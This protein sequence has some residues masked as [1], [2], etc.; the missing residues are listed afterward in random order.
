MDCVGDPIGEP[1]AGYPESEAWPFFAWGTSPEQSIREPSWQQGRLAALEQLAAGV[2]HYFTGFLQSI[3]IFAQQASFH[4]DIPEAARLNVE[5]IIH[6]ALQAADR[7]GQLRDFSGQSGPSKQPID[8]VSLVREAGYLLKRTLPSD[9]QLTVDI[10]P[11]CKAYGLN[12]DPIQIQRVLF[13]LAANAR[14]AM[15]MGGTLQV[16][17]SHFQSKLGQ[18]PSW[19]E[20]PSDDVQSGPGDWIALSFSDIGVGIP[21]EALPHIFE[22]FFSF[23]EGGEEAGLGLTQ[24]FGIVRRHGGYIDVDSQVGE[25]TTFTIYLPA[26]PSPRLTLPETIPG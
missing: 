19:S 2:A 1:V 15:S 8:L 7:V 9:I 20:T 25:G 24:A 22:P 12:A 23:K 26:L 6:H 17:L 3:I 10:A 16:R 13:N 5:R 21:P 11:G 4:P 18:P 14:D